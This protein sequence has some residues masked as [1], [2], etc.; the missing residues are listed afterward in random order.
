MMQGASDKAAYRDAMLQQANIA[1]ESRIEAAKERGATTRDIAQMRIDAQKD[2]A[3]LKAELNP[4]GTGSGSGGTGRTGV[5]ER[6]YTQGS[7]NSLNETTVA[8]KNISVLTN[9]GMNPLTGGA[10]SG[11]QGKSILGATGAWF[12][13][14]I[15]PE[16]QLQYESILE[17]VVYNIAQ[18][19]A[20]GRPPTEAQMESL[21]KSLLAKGSNIPHKVQLQKLGELTQIVEQAKKSFEANPAATPE[22]RAQADAAYAEIERFLPFSGTDVA[23]FSVYSKKN[24]NVT[25]QDWLKVNGERKQFLNTPSAIPQGA[26]QKLQANPT[27]AADFDKK[28]GAGASAKILGKK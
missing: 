11:L 14:A 25:F 24:P 6:I 3:K 23:K 13:N 2:L 7:L 10:L 27:L 19:R 5:Y 18:L 28:F 21:R 15:T 20:S 4:K 26:I 22:Q 16:D 17:P 8:A 12:G 9:Q 1:A